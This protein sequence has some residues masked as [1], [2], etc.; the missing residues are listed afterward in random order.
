MGLSVQVAAVVASAVW[1]VLL[2]PRRTSAMEPAPDSP[3]IALVTQGPDAD[4]LRTDIATALG[5][6]ASVLGSAGPIDP[7]TSSPEDFVRIARADELA[8]VL[9]IHVL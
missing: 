7:D 2:A 8:A 4:A 1:F 9:V 5:K 3:R 6:H